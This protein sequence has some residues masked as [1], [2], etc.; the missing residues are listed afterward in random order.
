[1]L[2]IHSIARY[3]NQ[4]YYIANGSVLIGFVLLRLFNQIEK[5]ADERLTIYYALGATALKLMKN[6]RIDSLDFVLTSIIFVAKLLTLYLLYSVQNYPYLILYTLTYALLFAILPQPV[7]AIQS[8]KVVYLNQLT[9]ADRLADSAAAPG[10]DFWLIEFYALW[11]PVSNYLATPMSTIANRYNK[12]LHV[13]KVDVGRWKPL[14]AKFHLDDSVRS[15][16]IPSVILF[17]NGVELMRMPYRKHEYQLPYNAADISSDFSALSLDTQELIE[18]F[19]L[20]KNRNASAIAAA[21]HLD[22]RGNTRKSN[23]NGSGSVSNSS[24]SKKTN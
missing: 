15:K 2:D 19:Q 18:Y 3:L 24:S 10:D 12:T 13:G 16:Q 6:R 8:T 5:S 9:M 7:A 4:R 11:S 17:R 14:T 1:M 23:N 22:K 21:E 20:E